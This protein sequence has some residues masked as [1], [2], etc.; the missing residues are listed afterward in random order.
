MSNGRIP[1]RKRGEALTR[2]RIR[3]FVLSLSL[4][5]LLEAAA[6]GSRAP[7]SQLKLLDL[8]GRQIDPL[9]K[10]DARAT[11]FVF[12]RSD[13]PISNRYAPEVRRLAQ[14]FAPS[15]ITFWLVYPD[16]DESIET[17]RRHL[18]EYDYRL[19][20]LRDA[21]Q[22]LV[23]ESGVQVTP[24]AAVFS[25]RSQLVYRGRIDNRFIDFGKA[26]PAPT[27][28]DLEEVLEAIIEGR[29]VASRTTSAVG[30]SIPQSR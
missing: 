5:V 28:R 6:P 27:T 30:C 8:N 3:R 2:E 21:N 18:K 13:C 26:R 14:Q 24:E 11:V 22:T 17:I 4:I 1:G 10:T 19:P 7:S 12:L 16:P 9:S 23:G 29:P 15:G 25:S 20:A